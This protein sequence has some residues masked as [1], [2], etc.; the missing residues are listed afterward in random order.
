MCVCVCVC[1]CVCACCYTEHCAH[2]CDHCLLPF[3]I[4]TT[5]TSSSLPSSTTEGPISPESK[6]AMIINFTVAAVVVIVV[7]QMVITIIVVVV[8]FAR[9]RRQH[10]VSPQ[11]LSSLEP[12]IT[13]SESLLTPNHPGILS[14]RTIGDEIKLLDQLGRGSFGTVYLGEQYCQ[15]H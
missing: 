14:Q 1:V 9:K 3:F 7:L 11:S 4:V 5:S 12:T 10:L 2:C 6:I 8:F 13:I 15:C